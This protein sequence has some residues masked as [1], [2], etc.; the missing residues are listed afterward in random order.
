MLWMGLRRSLSVVEPDGVVGGE[1]SAA[2]P[3]TPVRPQRERGEI[4]HSTDRSPGVRVIAADSCSIDLLREVDQVLSV[5]RQI[6]APFVDAAMEPLPR[7]ERVG[8]RVPLYDMHPLA[9]STM[10]YHAYRRF[11][12]EN[13]IEAAGDGS[14]F[15]RHRI[16][17]TGLNA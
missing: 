12:G 15:R 13:A 1:Q 4:W 11:T 8:I 5:R 7:L 2:S 17:T 6:A 9:W 14:G 10:E 3:T 16:L